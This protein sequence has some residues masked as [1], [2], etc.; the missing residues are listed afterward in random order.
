MNKQI[1]IIVE[2]TKREVGYWR[3]L[4]KA[5]FCETNLKVVPLSANGNLYMIWQQLQEDDNETDIIEVIRELSS[6]GKAALKGY[7]RDDFQEI[8]LFF[9][10]DPQQNNLGLKKDDMTTVLEKMLQTFNNETENG[11]LYISYPMCEALRDTD[12]VSC[13][14]RTSCFVNY[15]ELSQYKHLSGITN[16]F[17]DPRKYD[18]NIWYRFILIFLKRCSCIFKQECQQGALLN[19][20]KASVSTQAILDKESKVY[21]TCQRIFVLS[22]FP[23]FILEYF[24]KRALSKSL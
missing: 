8:Y 7:R 19:W 17:A 3:A 24:H 5:F 2:G 4:E 14:P 15:E 13:V 9:D 20:F 6:T 1:A 11:K 21:N 12:I 10:F 16:P 18:L 22:A 23:E